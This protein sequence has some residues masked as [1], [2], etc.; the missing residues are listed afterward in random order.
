MTILQALLGYKLLL[1]NS[2]ISARTLIDRRCS[3]L[4]CISTSFCKSSI[5]YIIYE[6]NLCWQRLM[7]KSVDCFVYPLVLFILVTT[8]ENVLNPVECTSV[9]ISNLLI[10]PEYPEVCSSVS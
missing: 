1:L 8:L 4:R 7:V 3:T 9:L 2:K 6:L 10:L 5:I